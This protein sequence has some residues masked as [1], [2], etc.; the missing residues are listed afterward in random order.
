MLFIKYNLWYAISSMQSILNNHKKI[1]P[2][3]YKITT[4][5]VLVLFYYCTKHIVCKHKQMITV[6]PYANQ[7]HID[8][9]LQN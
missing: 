3:F 9:S 1:T 8:E 2:I 4:L 5:G 7:K 6:W